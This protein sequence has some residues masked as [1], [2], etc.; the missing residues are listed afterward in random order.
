MNRIK[1]LFRYGV[2][3]VKMTALM[4]ALSASAAVRSYSDEEMA[5]FLDQFPMFNEC[6]VGDREKALSFYREVEGVQALLGEASQAI[7]VVDTEQAQEKVTE[8]AKMLLQQ[9]VEED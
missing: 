6:T 4:T 5:E 2:T 9:M 8:A 7:E 3:I 1:M